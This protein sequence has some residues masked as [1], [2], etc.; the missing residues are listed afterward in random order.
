MESQIIVLG[1]KS[2]WLILPA[3]AFVIAAT[4]AFSVWSLQSGFDVSERPWAARRLWA[5]YAVAYAGP[6]LVI[7][8][9]LSLVAALI[10]RRFIA[11]AVRD[12]VLEVVNFS[13]RRMDL[14]SLSTLEIG[15][16]LTFISQTGAR[17]ETGSL[18]IVGGWQ[19]VARKLRKI[20]PDVELRRAP[21]RSF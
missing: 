7:G 5:W 19:S 3:L 8:V 4:V 1:R 2:P 6:P 9:A 21:S 17:L 11:V 10:S 16:G 13:V 14:A 18:G 20:S 15:S 12:G